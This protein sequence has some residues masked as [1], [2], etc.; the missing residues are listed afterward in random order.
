[1]TRQFH[2]EAFRRDAVD[3]AVIVVVCNWTETRKLVEIFLLDHEHGGGEIERA[4][5]IGPP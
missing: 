2:F 3:Q 1:L 4:A 5:E